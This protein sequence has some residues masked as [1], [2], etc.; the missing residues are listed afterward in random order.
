MVALTLDPATSKRNLAGVNGKRVALEGRRRWFHDGL[1]S[2]LWVA[3]VG[4]IMSVVLLDVFSQVAASRWGFLFNV[5]T[6]VFGKGV[7]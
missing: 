4:S 3:N 2:A 7:Q 5:E 6:R 1:L